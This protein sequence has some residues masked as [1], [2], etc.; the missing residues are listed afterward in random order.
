MRG[1]TI[2]GVIFLVVGILG[3]IFGHPLGFAGLPRPWS[4][5]LGFALGV[6]TGAGVVLIVAAGSKKKI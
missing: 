5:L 4:F 2:I 3:I 1:R 6:A